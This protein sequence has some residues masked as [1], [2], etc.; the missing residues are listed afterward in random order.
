M[1]KCNHITKC[2]ATPNDVITNNSLFNVLRLVCMS[3]YG[4]CIHSFFKP[5][6]YH[7][8]AVHTW[9]VESVFVCTYYNSYGSNLQLHGYR[10]NTYDCNCMAVQLYT[11]NHNNI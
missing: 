10:Q 6:V 8:K 11:C 4:K 9:F 2:I 5:G 7:L 3:H 1:S